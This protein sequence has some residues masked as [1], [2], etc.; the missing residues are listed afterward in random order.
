MDAPTDTIL[1]RMT[2]RSV[3]PVTG[4][5]YVRKDTLRRICSGISVVPCSLLG[6]QHSLH[7]RENT[8]DRSL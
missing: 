7:H 6:T 4:E 2:L 8:A 3:D 5:R 1:E